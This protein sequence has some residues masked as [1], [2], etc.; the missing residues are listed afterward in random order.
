MLYISYTY[1]LYN[2]FIYYTYI[3][4]TIY[5]D[6]SGRHLQLLLLLLLLLL[7]QLLLLLLLV[8]MMI[9]IIMITWPTRA[10]PGKRCVRFDL[11]TV[12]RANQYSHDPN[13]Q[14]NELVSYFFILSSL[15]ILIIFVNTRVQKRYDLH[16]KVS[17]F[18]LSSLL[19]LML[20]S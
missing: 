19:I 9:I 6:G 8:I 7:L 12:F 18:L 2:V 3:L 17:L 16:I 13:S 15:L 14:I 1:I 5:R 11:H 20:I 4:Y 10:P